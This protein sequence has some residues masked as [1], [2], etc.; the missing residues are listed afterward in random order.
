[1]SDYSD[2][3]DEWSWSQPAESPPPPFARKL[4]P[5]STDARRCGCTCPVIDNGYGRGAYVDD[6]GVAQYWISGDCPL[7]GSKEVQSE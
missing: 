7:H 1:M 2:E 6:A 3:C 4:S 5:G